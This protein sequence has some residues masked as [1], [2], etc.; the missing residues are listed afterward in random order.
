MGIA[1][2]QKFS[3][4]NLHILAKIGNF[5][6]QKDM[7]SKIYETHS[8]ESTTRVIKLADQEV[9][10][11]SFLLSNAELKTIIVITDDDE[12]LELFI[13]RLSD[14]SDI[15]NSSELDAEKIKEKLSYLFNWLILSKFDAEEIQL[16]L[17]LQNPIIFQIFQLLRKSKS[18][19]RMR[20]YYILEQS[21]S[22][23]D[24][25]RYNFIIEYLLRLK[26]INIQKFGN[27]EL[28][29][30]IQDVAYYL[31]PNLPI[32]KDLQKKGLP[33]SLYPV[34]MEQ[35]KHKLRNFDP[36]R[37]NFDILSEILLNPELF[38]IILILKTTVISKTQINKFK[39][40]DPN[41]LKIPIK[42]LAEYGL[43]L[44]ISDENKEEYYILVE[45]ICVEKHATEIKRIYEDIIYDKVT[46]DLK[47]LDVK[48]DFD[49]K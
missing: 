10:Y 12:D 33:K 25:Q 6:L 21:F 43:V 23:L 48:I 20:L 19:Q 30:L 39:T 26:Y 40:L 38:K 7:L 1:I 14:F 9:F 32:L 17:E 45:D 4:E 8:N 29:D 49:K 36:F 44:M 28:I 47:K 2:A 37:L 24:L 13:P 42:V 15:I 11:L 18:L 41:T 27:N 31:K 22:F 16:M 46:K 5:E 35:I 34:A 3:E